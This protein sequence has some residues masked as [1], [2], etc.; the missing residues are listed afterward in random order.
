VRTIRIPQIRL[1]VPTITSL[2]SAVLQG[3]A[4]VAGCAAAFDGLGRAWGL[5]ACM[6]AGFVLNALIETPA[7]RP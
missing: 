7:K 4:L 6:V 3:G 2:R 1:R 5:A